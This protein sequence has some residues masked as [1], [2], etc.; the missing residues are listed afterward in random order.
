MRRPLI[1]RIFMT[2]GIVALIGAWWLSRPTSGGTGGGLV[3]SGTLTG[4][5]VK[6]S[7]EVSGTVRWLIEEGA[8]VKLGE[9][10][11]ELEDPVLIQQ[12][13]EAEAAL[14]AAQA[15]EAALEAGASPEQQAVLA[16]QVRQAEAEYQAA[17]QVWRALVRQL[18]EPQE[19]ERQ[20][21]EARTALAMAEQGVERARADLEKARADHAE[22]SAEAARLGAALGRLG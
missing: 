2:I 5:S 17:V 8:V 12:L 6:L 18:H 15:E 10:V 3:F 9:A 16:A 22:K 11:A 7:A 13:L 4:R 21:L 14:A 1:M 19:L 20:I